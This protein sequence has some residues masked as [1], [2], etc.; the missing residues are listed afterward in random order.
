MVEALR[1]LQFLAALVCVAAFIGCAN[2]PHRSFADQKRDFTDRFGEPDLVVTLE[3]ADLNGLGIVDVAG[4]LR[5]DLDGSV[6]RYELGYLSATGD[7]IEHY[8]IDGAAVTQAAPRTLRP[9]NNQWR[10]GS[11]LVFK[12]GALDLIMNDPIDSYQLMGSASEANVPYANGF[13]TIEI[14]IWERQQVGQFEALVAINPSA[15]DIAQS[16][17]SDTNGGNEIA[18]I[19]G[20]APAIALGFVLSPVTLPATSA[21]DKSNSIQRSKAA[22]IPV[23]KEDLE[24]I[25]LGAPF[26]VPVAYL[27]ASDD[28]LPPIVSRTAVNQHYDTLIVVRVAAKFVGSEGIAFRHFALGERDGLIV[29]KDPNIPERTLCLARHRGWD[30]VANCPR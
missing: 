17:S 10:R 6:L 8:V 11:L 22:D 15:A 9:G 20:F 12:N 26:R 28:G 7:R 3:A 14:A 29:W 23:F 19:I 27:A 16:N 2:S 5:L 25:E 1:F 13:D 24:T 21:I 4:A 18:T 30:A